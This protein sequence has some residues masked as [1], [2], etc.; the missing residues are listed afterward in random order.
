MF[1]LFSDMHTQNKAQS[2][3]LM[4]KLFAGN[5]LEYLGGSLSAGLRQTLISH[6][7]DERRR[8][9]NLVKNNK[10]FNKLI[11]RALRTL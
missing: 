11:F 8:V 1:P 10:H 7:Y 2:L 6:C 3:F 5:L 4:A 9:V